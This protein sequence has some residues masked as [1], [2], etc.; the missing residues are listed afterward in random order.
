MKTIV[1][2]F[3]TIAL[4]S[5]CKK[6]RLKDEKA[7]FIGKWEW[8]TTHHYYN[9]CEG[10]AVYETLTPISEGSLFQLEFQTKGIFIFRKNSLLISSYKIKF[11]EFVKATGDSDLGWY[12]FEIKLDNEFLLDD[13]EVL[14]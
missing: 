14:A 4:I 12:H 6:D 8:I 1:I 10:S 2:I 9:A 5:S 7:I 3:C 13:I 11:D